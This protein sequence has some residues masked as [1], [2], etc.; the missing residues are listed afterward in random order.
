MSGVDRCRQAQLLLIE[1]EPTVAR[2]TELVLE[3]EGY[4]VD[5]LADHAAARETLGGKHYDLV[6][7]DTDLGAKS[8]GLKGLAPLV[9][10]AAPSPVL[11][12][13]AHRFPE[14][15]VMAAGLAGAVSK[16]Y[17]IDDLLRT[18]GEKLGCES[19]PRRAASQPTAV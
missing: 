6:L 4:A 18:V 15:E 1:D 5:V 17:D 8:D 16:P 14:A 2:L 7:A 19:D 3:S 12:F 10:A 11:L 13:S 9:E